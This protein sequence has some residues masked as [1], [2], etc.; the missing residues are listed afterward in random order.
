MAVSDYGMLCARVLE[1]RREDGQSTPHYQIHALAAQVHYR[2][3]V[4]VK[5]QVSQSDLLFLI[6]ESFSHPVTASLSGLAEGFHELPSQRGGT[7]LDYIR[8][9]LFDR[10]QMRPLPPSLPGADNDLADRL[11]HFVDRAA[12]DAEAR[13]Y[14]FGA[15]WGPEPEKE[16]KVFEFLPGN[17]VHDIHMNQGNDPGHR[18]DD[19]V[20][21]DGALMLRFGAQWVAI[22]LAFQ[23]Q[24][25][26]TD[27]ET[28]HAL[29]EPPSGPGADPGPDEPDHRLRIVAA[30]ANAIG[31]APEAESVTLLNRTPT[32]VDLDGWE[33]VDRMGNRQ[34]LS[35]SI[36]AGAALRLAVALPVALGNKGGT[37]TLLDKDG[38]KV[39][40]VAY[41]A[42]DA[43]DEGWTIV[44]R[45]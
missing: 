39:D 18:G 24:A 42:A 45:G 2:L 37:V 7:A 43:E 21:Q 23:S 28:G 22:F 14:A 4:N 25:W 40:G 5:S 17:G 3:A 34:E 6:D 11:A 19:G 8:G 35:G 36:E 26:H 30:L 41:T 10:T 9:N 32:A 1:A 33:L 27:D 31:P 13:V 20:W 44:F 16:D 38:L 29:T 12:Q 15:H